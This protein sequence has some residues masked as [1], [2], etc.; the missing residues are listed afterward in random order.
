MANI[1]DY[2]VENEENINVDSRYTI[3]PFSI[4]SRWDKKTFYCLKQEERKLWVDTMRRVLYYSDIYD[5][6]SIGEVLGNGK[7]GEVRKCINKETG[8]IVAIKIL[9]KQKMR[10]R[11]YDMVRNEIEAL[12]LCQHKNIVR[13]YDVLENVNYIF[14]VM[15]YLTGGTLRDYMK[16]RNNQIT[17]SQAKSYVKSI[18]LALKYI[19]QF[20]ILHRDIKLINIL[21]T[22]DF[23]LKL[24]DF[25]LAVILGPSELCKGYA[26]TLDFCSPE[27]IIDLPYSQKAD[28]WGMGVVAWYLLNGSLPFISA[29]SNDLKKYYYIF[30][31]RLILK[32][33]PR[34]NKDRTISPEAIDFL[35]SKV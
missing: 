25:G 5:I 28:I 34:F 2:F 19:G 14:L 35:K 16:E 20:G 9:N 13:L 12:K 11:N 29:N 30:I 23:V 8:K 31:N 24:A 26:G 21:F 18:A 6:Y 32:D 15:E 3:C 1:K 22:D 27:V 17:E 7:Y 10:I 4:C 33:E